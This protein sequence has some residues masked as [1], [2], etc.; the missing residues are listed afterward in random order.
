M[1]RAIRDWMHRRSTAMITGV[2][3]Q[4]AVAPVVVES[5]NPAPI[6]AARDN[7]REQNV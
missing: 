4:A 6:M 3:G 5:P 7:P 2:Y 1:Q